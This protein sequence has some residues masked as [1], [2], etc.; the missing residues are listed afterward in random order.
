MVK[1]EKTLNKEN[2]LE[3]IKKPLSELIREARVS[4]NLSQRAFAKKVGITQAQL[5][6][7]EN[8]AAQKPN[9]RTLQ[10]LA[11]YLD[12]VSYE[13]MLAMAGYSVDFTEEPLEY[14]NVYDVEKQDRLAAGFKEVKPELYESARDLYKYLDDPKNMVL[15]D[16]IFALIKAIGEAEDQENKDTLKQRYLR[17]C[18]LNILQ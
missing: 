8:G 13:A 7:L 9:R 3:I 10:L 12:S 11:P 16:K 17:D 4:L 15:L 2:D 14:S 6:R 5:S 18:I 1:M